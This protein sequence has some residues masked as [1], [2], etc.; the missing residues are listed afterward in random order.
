MIMFEKHNRVSDQSSIRVSHFFCK[1]RSRF[2]FRHF[3]LKKILKMFIMEY[4]NDV[5]T[6]MSET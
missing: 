5:R 6:I 1:Q 4:I 3:S 2:I